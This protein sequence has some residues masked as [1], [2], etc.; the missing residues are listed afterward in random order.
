M[1]EVTERDEVLQAGTGTTQ[2]G[3]PRKV[4][5]TPRIA[6][7]LKALRLGRGNRAAYLDS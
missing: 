7:H 1:E 3:K 4:I 2:G 5:S 6:L